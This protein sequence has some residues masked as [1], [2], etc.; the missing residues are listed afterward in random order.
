MRIQK[1]QFSL[2]AGALV[3]ALG[4]AA[5]IQ[6]GV[7]AYS[8]SIY[9][10]LSVFNQVL[11]IVTSNYVEE[12]GVDSLLDGAIE[13]MLDQLDPHTTYVD[14]E[15]FEQM[16]ER[17]RGTYS[18][19]GIEF[20][21][22]EDWLTVISP[23]EGGPS[24]ELGIRPGDVITKIEGE[25]AFGIKTDEVFEKLRGRKG[26]PVHVTVRRE[27]EP[28]PLEFTIIRDN[29]PIKSVPYTFMLEPGVGYV[30]LARFSATTSDELEEAMQ[31]LE[32]QGMKELILDL[33]GNSG[34]FL[35]EAIE[36]SDKFIEGGRKLVYTVGRID[37]SSEEYFST[38]RATHERF[39]LVVLVD[40]GSASA[41]EIVSG[42]IQDWDRGYVV[43]ETTFGK[44]LVQRQFPLKN[45]GAL[46]VTV[47]RYFTPSGRLIQRDYSDKEEYLMAHRGD[48]VAMDST[49][50]KDRPIFYTAGGRHVYGGGGVTPDV[51]IHVDWSQ[52]DLQRE[53][54][55]DRSYFDYANHY[56]GSR[57][58]S[59]PGTFETFRKEF[60]VDDAMLNDFNS[61][62]EKRKFTVSIDSLK[63]EYDDVARGIRREMA[64]NLWGKNERAHILMEADPV[65]PQALGLLPQAKMMAEGNIP[66]QEPGL[67]EIT[68]SMGPEK[69]TKAEEV[70][71][72]GA[73]Q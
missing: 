57:H 45:G 43:G 17:N 19:V 44:G 40:R 12:V 34:G 72:P 65:L 22:V 60:V 1:T 3:L 8:D 69:E 41:S 27:G 46:L 5:G 13:G 20:D 68:V 14:P 30:R 71:E 70:L 63:A 56:I 47:A 35:N 64:R 6:Q 10:K 29:I 62:I 21:I 38:G 23:L 52:S 18:G 73:P 26:S 55:R 61:F 25:S 37:G 50:L 51:V 33:R 4:L 42:A 9:T 53:L 7:R 36:V 39:P 48:E 66:A 67:V 54:E 11:N 32:K 24:Y 2:L 58:Y 15:R 49:K 59:W 28:E 16:Q 31:M